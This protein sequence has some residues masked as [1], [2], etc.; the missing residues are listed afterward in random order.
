MI[1]WNIVK[2]LVELGLCL[3]SVILPAVPYPEN[4]NALT[5]PLYEYEYDDYGNQTLIRDNVKQ[6]AAEPITIIYDRERET[7]FTY[8]ELHQQTSRT[9]PGGTLTETNEYDARGRLRLHVDFKG[10]GTGYFYNDLGQL[11]YKNSYINS[12]SYNAGDPEVGWDEQI[13]YAYD[14][15]GRTETEVDARGTTIYYYDAEGNVEQIDSPE[16]TVNY[17]YSPVTS[18]KVRTWTDQTETRFAYD[19]LGR[20]KETKL[21]KRDGVDLTAAPNTPE[22]TNYDYD[23]VGNRNWLETNTDGV[24]GFEIKADYT[25][26][27]LNRLTEVINQKAT[28]NLSTFTHHLTADGMRDTITEMQTQPGTSTAESRT[29]SNGYDNLNRLT[30]ESATGNTGSYSITYTYDLVGNRTERTVN[31]NGPLL[32]TNY[33]YNDQDQLETE[34]HI[35]PVTAIPHGDDYV[36]A[37]ANSGGGVDYRLPNHRETIHPLRAFWM[38]LPS[39]IWA[40]CLALALALIPAAFIA[41]VLARLLARFR[42]QSIRPYPAPKPVFALST[43][44]IC[45]MLAIIFLLG[46]ASFE[47]MANQSSL[48]SNITRSHWGTPGDTITYSYDLNGSMTGKVTTNGATTTETVIYEYNLQNRLYKVTTWDGGANDEV[49]EYTYNTDGIR[50]KAYSYTQPHN[51]GTKSNE[52]TTTYLIDSYNHTGYAQVLEETSVANSTTTRITYTL[53]DDVIAQKDSSLSDTQFLLYDGHGSTRQLA[54]STGAVTDCYSYDAYGMM[55]GGNPTPAAPAATNLLYTGEQY[56]ANLQQYYLRARY[57]DSS[58]GRFHQLDPFAGNYSDPQSLHKYLYCHANPVNGIDPTGEFL[59]GISGLTL[60]IAIGAILTNIGLTVY[61]G[62]RHGQSG[63]GIAWSVIQNLA[64][65]VAIAGAIL[66]SGPIAL[67]AALTLIVVSI[68]GIINLIRSWPKMDT[69]DKVVTAATMLTFIVFA[70]AIKAGASPTPEPA[71]QI[72]GEVSVLPESYFSHVAVDMRN[73]PPGSQT[74][75]AGFPRNGP[76]FWRQVRSRKPEYFST[77]NL[78]KISDNL[79]PKVNPQW[80]KYHPQHQS[81]MGDTLIH[82]HIGQGPIAV[83]MPEAV[84]TS[85]ARFLNTGAGTGG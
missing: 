4:G 26:D 13:E 9:L 41:P 3:S 62:I 66:L 18:R 65:F 81:F 83:G 55:L 85:W 19:E 15:L 49:V 27:N 75:A 35:E 12:S 51:G 57:Y 21:V 34:T 6:Y 67:V 44:C 70:G 2:L 22:V 24:A 10:Q 68:V 45:A 69:T 37:Y 74:N 72:S 84:H 56:D 60:S 1:I 77:D 46:P 42:K 11:W 58:N 29:V 79:A 17:E 80:V 73:A 31:A 54:D 5:C 63:L 38:G 71:P 39:K 48:Y 28:A 78:Q 36:Y 76:W 23:A 30:S 20:L 33:D 47:V 7:T 14:D 8:N 59:G 64:T 40:Y 16:G 25:Y 50:V 43:R 61:S 52:K 53:G 82:H 32:Q